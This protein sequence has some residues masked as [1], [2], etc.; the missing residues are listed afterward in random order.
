[1]LVLLT[2][3]TFLCLAA[4]APSPLAPRWS[5]CETEPL[6]G[7]P[8]VSTPLDTIYGLGAYAP[9]ISQHSSYC[10]NVPDGFVI[11]QVSIVSRHGARSPTASALKSIQSSLA[12]LANVTITN[13]T[14][15]FA[16]SYS[17]DGFTA[18]ALTDYGRYELYLSGATH[19]KIYQDLAHD[20][21][22]RASGEQRVIESSQYFLQGFLG[23]DFVIK[24]TSDLPEPQVIISETTGLNN[25]LIV[26]NCPADENYTPN[27]ET[28]AQT[29]WLSVN[30]KRGAWKT[31][32]TIQVYTP[33]IISRLESQA[34]G[35]NLTGTDVLNFMS[36]CGFDAINQGTTYAESE[37]CSLFEADE[38]AQNGYY[39]DVEKW[40]GH[41]YGDPYVKAEYAGFVNELIARLN[42]SA[43]L[44]GGAIN[45]T[46]DTDPSTFPLNRT[47]YADFTQ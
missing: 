38:W 29:N 45:T 31:R 41:S 27:L 8:N 5:S 11:D 24:N 16:Q 42:D 21:F 40:W 13:E 23:E 22:A 30:C 12:K 44:L 25:T 19:A 4:A 28:T 47:F 3:F 9:Y 43:P 18:D 39:F 36:L 20:I 37:W 6:S 35:A 15:A 7:P 2:S 10:R 1:M 46:L 34:S 32:L 14:L 33:P 26:S 17:L